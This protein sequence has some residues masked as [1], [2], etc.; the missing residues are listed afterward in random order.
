VL[1]ALTPAPVAPLAETSS[2]TDPVL[3]AWRRGEAP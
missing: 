2:G 3:E 1:Y